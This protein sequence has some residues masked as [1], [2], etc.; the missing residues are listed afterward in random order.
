M[1]SLSHL[2]RNFTL[3]QLQRHQL[4]TN[5]LLQFTQWLS[6]AVNQ[7]ADEA[8]M[9]TLSTVD[10]QSRPHARVVLLKG[11]DDG[12][13]QFFTNYDSD[14]GRQIAANPYVAATFYWGAL[15]RQVRIEGVAHR[16]NEAVN[17]AYFSSRP[18]ESRVAACASPQSR[19]VNDDEVQGRY[20]ALMDCLL[21][22]DIARPSYWGG[23]NIVPHRFEFWQGGIH[24]LHDRFVYTLNEGQWVIDRLAP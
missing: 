9:M 5:P 15:E 19:P 7:M 1:D 20:R 17:E 24:R 11:V 6:D 22:S 23:Y 21:P 10:E 14:K 16:C 13:L 18:I 2:R 8:T 12:M 4:M 3:Q